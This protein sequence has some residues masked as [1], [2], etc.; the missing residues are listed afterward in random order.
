MQRIAV[1]LFWFLAF[2]A[3]AAYAEAPPRDQQAL[4][5]GLVR[6]FT[7]YDALVPGQTQYF[8]IEV[9]PEQ[10]WHSY[11]FNPGDSG[12]AP[13]I[14]WILPQSLTPGEMMLP[15]PIRLKT[16]GFTNY[17]FAR[18]MTIMVPVSVAADLSAPMVPIRAEVR[19][20]LCADI[21]VPYNVTLELSLPVRAAAN[22]VNQRYLSEIQAAWPKPWPHK[23]LWHIEGEDFHLTFPDTKPAISKD[24]HDVWF[25][26]RQSG[27]TAHDGLAAITDN[28]GA[29]RITIP[30]G[31]TKS[32]SGDIDGVLSWRDGPDAGDAQHHIAIKASAPAQSVQPVPPVSALP[33]V[34][35]TAKQQDI[36]LL[37][38]VILAFLGGAL[39][40]FMPCV[41]PVLAL[42]IMA[43]V[44]HHDQRRLLWQENIGYAAGIIISFL[45]L[46]GV[47]MALRGAGA[48]IGWGFQLQEPLVIWGLLVLFLVIALALGFDVSLGGI[49]I[50]DKNPNRQPGLGRGFATGM[51]VAVVA[52]PCT[53][54]MMAAALGAALVMPVWQGGMVFAALG[55]GLAMPM[56]LVTL[57]PGLARFVPRPGAWM[58]HLRQAMAFPMMAAALWLLWV[59]MGQVDRLTQG[60]LLVLL[61]G[62]ALGL[63]GMRLWRAGRLVLCAILIAMAVIGGNLVVGKVAVAPP[64][65][66]LETPNG[67]ISWHPYDPVRVADALAQGQSVFVDATADWCITCLVNERTAL[68]SKVVLTRFAEG[69]VLLLRADWTRRDP[70]VTALL[71]QHQRAG[72]PLYVMYHPGKPP[73]VLPQILTESILLQAIDSK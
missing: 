51:L 72:V 25:F 9:I 44:R 69:N 59:L 31:S 46:G 58:G 5:H 60:W 37:L 70:V 13:E 24:A 12:L 33:H 30:A 52:S 15:A 42:K 8:A 19:F 49:G 7:E 39:L 67:T 54:P 63:W 1:V 22:P 57:V 16:D 18:T 36:G 66:G 34:E 68:A 53:A 14:D 55:L 29:M 23:V 17:G 61:M 65:S 4:D 41:F 21:C 40:N 50:E 43:F 71:E 2:F 47:M 64:V 20:L 26:V 11:W 3:G 38:A 27:L 73:M 48:A 35:T 32:Q 45:V 10:G 62:M 6:L 56:M 28:N